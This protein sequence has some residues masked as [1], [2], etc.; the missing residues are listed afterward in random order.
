MNSAPPIPAKPA[1]VFPREAASLRALTVTMAVMC[2]LACLAIGALVVIHRATEAWSAGISREVTVQV[3]PLSN[4]NIDD[5]ILKAVNV[6]QQ[7][8]GVIHVGVLDKQAAARLLEP[9]LGRAAIDDL[10][11]PRLI[12]VTIDETHPPDFD[13]LQ[14]NLQEVKGASLDTH[15]RWQAELSRLGNVLSLLAALV[16]VLISVASVTL[17]AAAARGVIETHRSIVDVL[18]LIGAEHRFIARQNDRQFLA[19]GLLAGM[20]GLIAG[21]ATFAVLGLAGGAAGEGITDTGRSL[22][23]A[24]ADTNVRMALSLL[25]VPVLATLIAVG[26]SRLTLMRILGR[27]S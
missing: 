21:L 2:Y 8:E 19:S 1:P 3:R 22:L 17:V 16:L 27:D 7:T 4:A 23:Y 12:R 13:A 14:K 10:P 15:R 5:E 11:V 20:L 9:W 25:A 18:E 6:L 24:P 26:A